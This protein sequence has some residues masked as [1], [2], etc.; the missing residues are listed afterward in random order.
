MDSLA[1]NIQNKGLS[2][3]GYVIMTNHMHCILQSKGTIPL[4]D[5]I[6]DFKKFTARQIINTIQS[7]P[8]SRREWMMHRFKWNASIRQRKSNHQLWQHSNHAE[9]IFTR[10]F[11]D[12]KLNYIHLN[13]VKAGWV[14]FPQ[15]YI[16]SSAFELA[17]R[18]NKIPVTPWV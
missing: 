8:E 5:I 2:V 7:E 11:F 15:D 13:P 17:K 9:E 1:F 12:Q 3:Y 14:S 18:G 16:Y 6:R 4:Y 10:P